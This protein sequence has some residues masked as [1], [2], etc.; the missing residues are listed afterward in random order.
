M[1]WSLKI[2][3]FGETTLRVHITFFLLLIWVAVSSWPFG[4]LAAALDGIFFVILIFVCVIL[5]EFGHV[6]AARRY[7][8]KTPDI[9]VLPIG[10]LARL[11]RMP[12]KPAQELWVAIAGPL[13]NVAIAAV[14]FMLLGARFDLTDMAEFQSA[15]GSLQ[16]RVAAVNLLIV[17]FNLIPAFPLDGGR[18]LRAALAFRLDRARA[19]LIAARIGQT[20]AIVFAVV[21]LFYN[22]FL[23]LIAIFL[24][25]AADAEAGHESMRAEARGHTARDAMISRYEGLTPG[26]SAEDAAN[27]LIL[28]TQQEFP[29]IAADGSFLGLVTRSGLIAAMK[30]KGPQTPVTDFME[31]GIE[32]VEAGAPLDDVLIKLYA[33]PSRAVAVRGAGGR[34]AGY[35]NGENASELFLLDRA[36]RAAKRAF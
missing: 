31:T 7:G 19:T 1:S 16:G 17:A 12:E 6:L 22:P 26:Q 34:F 23:L 10:G 20:F 13:V 25:F 2:A 30:E 36:R 3:D 9:T 14:L 15:Q 27:L 28:T 8:I 35:I 18:M 32:T 5:H 24:F 29:V 33:H 4:G 21:G 11:E